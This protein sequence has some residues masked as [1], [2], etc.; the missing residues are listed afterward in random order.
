MV[1]TKAQFINR[2]NKHG[3]KRAK[4]GRGFSTMI[5]R[6]GL[7]T[8]K[9]KRS[10]GRLP[11][12]GIFML[13]AG[14]IGFKAFMLAAVGPV[15]YNERLAKLDAGTKI[16]KVGAKVMAIDPMTAALADFAGPVIR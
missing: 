16:E 2:L 7:I 4:Q 15:T 12:M 6:D 9:L 8:V 1:E 3:L 13:A 14:F 5:G 10:R 11:V